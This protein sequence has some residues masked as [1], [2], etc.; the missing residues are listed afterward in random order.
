M[1]LQIP[2]TPPSVRTAR[3]AVSRDR[4]LAS[5]PAAQRDDVVLIISE[6]VSNAVV[7]APTDT[8]ITVRMDDAPGGLR[9]EVRNVLSGAATV[10]ER[11]VMPPADHPSGRGLALVRRMSSEVAI[12]IAEPPT[13]E[14]GGGERRVLTVT[15][16]VRLGAHPGTHPGTHPGARPGDGGGAVR[17]R[18]RSAD[19]TEPGHRAGLRA[20]GR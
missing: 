16:V 1:E 13:G 14:P 4:V 9:I 12:V 19:A 7:A 6:L 17:R 10:P 15:A 18:G 11:E 8:A 2:A 20:G 3:S 5:L